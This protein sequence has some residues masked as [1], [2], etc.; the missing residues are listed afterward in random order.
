MEVVESSIYLV[1]TLSGTCRT[2]RRMRKLA[3]ALVKVND[4]LASLQSAPTSWAD[5]AALAIPACLDLH[6]RCSSRHAVDVRVCSPLN[7]VTCVPSIL[8]DTH[9]C[10]P[11]GSRK[12]S[13][14]DPKGSSGR[15]AVCRAAAVCRYKVNCRTTCRNS[16]RVPFSGKGLVE[17]GVYILYSKAILR[18]VPI[19]TFGS[20]GDC[21]QD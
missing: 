10:D 11:E 9:H 8:S 20:P 13:E 16:Q 4:Q 5:A 17:I 18:V 6:G 3:P 15:N 7:N 21:N 19:P 1:R 12:R 2:S 14:R